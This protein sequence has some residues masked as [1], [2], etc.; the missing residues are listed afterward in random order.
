LFVGLLVLFACRL[1]SCW[2]EAGLVLIGCLQFVLFVVIGWLVVCLIAV[3]NY[4]YDAGGLTV[5]YYQGVLWG[6]GRVVGVNTLLLS[7]G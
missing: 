3:F 1:P 7:F 4:L 5:V 6:A 2:C